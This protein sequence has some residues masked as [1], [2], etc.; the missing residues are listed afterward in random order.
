MATIQRF[1]DLEIW[2]LARELAKE[3]FILSK[4]GMLSKDFALK[5]QMNRSA[6]SIMDNI[7]EGFG[8]SSRLE[9]IQFLSIA[10][11]SAAELQS[12]IY[13]CYDK[14]YM[15]EASFNDLAEKT[16]AIYKK[17][18]GFIKYLNAS[19]IKG[20]KFKERVPT[21]KNDK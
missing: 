4:T 13:R 2:Q 16:N 20:T 17:T 9:F 6:G 5:D 3:I 1:E 14:E 18:N 10:A 7:A 11:G 8:R 19:I 15:N 21:A 12:Q